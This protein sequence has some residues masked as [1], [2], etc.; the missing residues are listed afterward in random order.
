MQFSG[1]DVVEAIA[2]FAREYGIT[3]I[4]V[5]R[6]QRPWYSRWLGPSIL[7]RLIRAV[8]DATVI[9]PGQT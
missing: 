5:G 2:N 3:H 7:D 6:S 9:V 8:P 1:R 4:V